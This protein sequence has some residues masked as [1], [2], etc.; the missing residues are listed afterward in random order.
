V[1]PN[2]DIR[3]DW[4]REEAGELYRLP[5]GELVFRAQQVHRRFFDPS[6]VQLS[7]LLSIKTGNCPEDCKYCPQSR[8]YATGLEDRPLTPLREVREAALQ[9]RQRGATR[10]CMGAAW[11]SPKDR[12]MELLEAMVREVRQL[13]M[14]SCMT[15][16]M[17][18]ASQARRL[19]AAGLDY[20][21]H[22]LDTSPEYY[23][24]IISTRTYQHRL[25]T[26]ERVREAGIKV[27][28]GGIVGMGEDVGDRIGLLVQL[29]NL[30]EHP[31]S[32]PINLLVRVEGTPLASEEDLDPLEFVRTMALARLLMPASYLRLSA[33]RE[34]M[35]AETQALAFMAGANSIFYGDQLLTTSNPETDRDMIL[36]RRLGMRPEGLSEPPPA[37]ASG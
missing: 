9:A 30:P 22:N 6:T 19:A 3:H 4:T 27:C 21:N 35:S 20:Y 11:R 13:G 1:E 23:G 29:A 14:E 24:E 17:L 25:E 7:T 36:L 8:R 2:S 26:L 33:G 5:F 28:C 16:G 31:Q 18:K 15:L 12:D 34:Q 10:F 37:A 32:V